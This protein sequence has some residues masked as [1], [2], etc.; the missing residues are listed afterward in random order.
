MLL[1]FYSST[2][3][4]SAHVSQIPLFHKKSETIKIVVVIGIIRILS[5]VFLLSKF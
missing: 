3:E 1:H 5:F 4:H 2:N